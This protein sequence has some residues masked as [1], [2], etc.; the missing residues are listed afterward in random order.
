MKTEDGNALCFLYKLRFI[1]E[2]FYGA[3]QLARA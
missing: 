3:V 2:I 1:V